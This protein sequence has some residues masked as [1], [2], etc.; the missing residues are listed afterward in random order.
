MN[1]N[2]DKHENNWASTLG[3]PCLRYLYLKR[4]APK[5]EI[6]SDEKKALFKK[7]NEI[8]DGVIN[9]FKRDGFEII[10]L[11]KKFELKEYSIVGKIDCILK[12]KELEYPCEIKSVSD[13]QWRKIY[14]YKDFFESEYYYIKMYPIQLQLYLHAIKKDNGFFYLRNKVTSAGRFV[15]VKYDDNIL[16]S[17]FDKAKLVNKHVKN[18]I[19]PNKITD[20]SIC[21]D[22]G[23]Y[24]YCYK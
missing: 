21:Q 13:K 7:G 3:H 20:L 17:V 23:F 24:N 5:L 2:I 12:Y 18:N 15:K 14:I 1:L 22:C 6:I 19:L 4:T 11:Q 8:E 9:E 16:K 10:A